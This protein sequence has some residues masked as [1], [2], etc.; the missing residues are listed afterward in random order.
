MMDE[1]QPRQWNV[2]DNPTLFINEVPVFENNKYYAEEA[3]RTGRLLIDACV[4]ILK[5]VDD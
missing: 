3:V 5:V 2:T 4:Q 1:F